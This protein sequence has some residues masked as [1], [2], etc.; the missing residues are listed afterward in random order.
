MKN[1][2]ENIM[3]ALNNLN[4]PR[5]VTLSTLIFQI[6]SWKSASQNG[7][8]NADKILNLLYRTQDILNGVNVN[9]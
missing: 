5:E 8:S 7:H 6:S 4:E 1:I 3:N 2:M 9:K